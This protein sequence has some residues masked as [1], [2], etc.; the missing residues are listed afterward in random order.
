MES[1]YNRRNRQEKIHIWNDQKLLI[2]TTGFSPATRARMIGNSIVPAC[3]I[4]IMRAIKKV[5]DV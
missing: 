3:V 4:P 2:I 1:I 5:G